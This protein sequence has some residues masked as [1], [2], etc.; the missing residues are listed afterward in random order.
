MSFLMW[1]SAMAVLIA[2]FPEADGRTYDIVEPCCTLGRNPERDISDVFQ[3]HDGVSREHARIEKVGDQ[4][5]L[6][7]W[8]SRNGTQK[9][10]VEVTDSVAL[11]D[12]DRITICAMDFLFY[13]EAPSSA[14]G[15]KALS[16][17]RFVDS[18]EESGDESS[19]DSTLSADLP[20]TAGRG[21]DRTAVEARLDA[22]LKMLGSLGQSFEIHH[23]LDNL[24]EALFRIF[25]QADRGFIGLTEGGQ[26]VAPAAVKHREPD[27]QDQIVVSRTIVKH[28]ME[29]REA[30]RCADPAKEALFSDGDSVDEL[31]GRSILCAPLLTADGRAAGVVQL[32][33][34]D[35]RN[36]FE[37]CDLEILVAVTRLV[38]LAIEYADL[39]DRAV[40]QKATEIDLATAH[41]VQE[42]ILPRR[43]AD[44]G[45]YQFHAHYKAA[46]EV[47]GDYYE[48]V[49][50]PDG[51][52]AVILADASGKG[53]SAAIMTA[54]LSGEL[55]YWLARE[56][57]PAEVLTR[58]NEWFHRTGPDDRFVTLV[59]A[60]LHPQ[61]HQVMLANAGHYAPLLRRAD[62]EV[63]AVEAESRRL[64]LGVDPDEQYDEF[65]I[66]LKP[67]DYLTI[68][69]DG[70]IDAM[71]ADLQRYGVPRLSDTI[72]RRDGD[73]QQLAK[74]IVTDVHQFVGSHPQ[75]DDICLICFGRSAPD[76]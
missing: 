50:L 48:Y 17:T 5:F 34:V 43:S 35:S 7:D 65:V 46:R 49:P 18:N 19:Y 3:G 2:V 22:I 38:T 51:G 37:H 8:D 47:G 9:N 1:G 67:G 11:S 63:F 75:I 29:T 31:R 66:E 27:R 58:V 41:R 72:A 40:G 14:F 70:V 52:L 59:V 68:F 10:G 15:Y 74:H 55:K 33:S 39:H 69:S 53:V 44:L 20:T 12:G 25:G 62:G 42:S 6:I 54:S 13:R 45:G 71:D 61:S 23:V 73:A 36:P 60:A 57:S 32:D 24:L 30:V 16:L 64:P 76:D 21:I 4:Y 56:F 26:P 28:V